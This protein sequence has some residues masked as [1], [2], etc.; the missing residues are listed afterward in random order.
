MDTA[1]RFDAL[2]A[3]LRDDV[4]SGASQ[5]AAAAAEI[6]CQAADGVHAT[7][8]PSLRHALAHLGIRILEAQPAMAPLVALVSDVLRATDRAPSVAA[9]RGSAHAAARAFAA[10]MEERAPRIAERAA[11][12]LPPGARVLT[13]SSSA[14]VVH[15][16]Q[17]AGAARVR[18]V[19]VLESRPVR[20]GRDAARA[21]A[22]A[23][24]PVTFAVDAA[25]GALVWECDLV[26]LGAD[27][28]G[29]RGCVNKIGSLPLALAA[30]EAGVPVAV[31]ADRAKILPPGFPQLL[32]D[33]RPA[34]QVWAAPEGVTVWNRYFEA[35]PLELVGHLVTDADVLTP[36]EVTALR[37]SLEIPPELEGWVHGG[38]APTPDSPR[39]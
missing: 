19:V 37:R 30:R 8:V 3:P 24:L 4:V 11:A 18:E 36:D 38:G 23:G 7:D 9:A 28:I 33:D 2:I 16:L 26:L 31:V 12:L 32:A 21:L 17:V 20:E 5:V 27:S 6:L 34:E 25:A 10:G 39:R 1:P 13:L 22:G 35:F 15:A 14:T 29:D